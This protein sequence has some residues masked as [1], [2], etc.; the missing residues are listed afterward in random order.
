MDGA[1]SES[2]TATTQ[3]TIPPDRAVILLVEDDDAVRRLVKR[4][5]ER[6]GH[7]VIEATD[8][9]RALE[10]AREDLTI[11]L[12][13]SDVVMPALGGHELAERLRRERPDLKVILTSG[14]SDADLRGEVRSVSDAFLVKP[15]TPKDLLKAVSDVLAD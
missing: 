3:S 2:A 15:F 1:G 13:V 7:T 14:Y 9:R 4:T 12:L 5:L 8:G 6:R 10:K 11:D